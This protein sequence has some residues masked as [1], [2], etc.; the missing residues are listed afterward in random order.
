MIFEMKSTHIKKRV[1]K[2]Q[3]QLERAFGYLSKGFI[4]NPKIELFEVYGNKKDYEIRHYK[5]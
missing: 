2:A 5:T 3:D 4:R 1:L